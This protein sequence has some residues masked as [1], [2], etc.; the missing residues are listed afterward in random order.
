MGGADCT[1]SP[2]EVTDG[3]QAQAGDPPA[4]RRNGPGSAVLTEWNGLSIPKEG[5]FFIA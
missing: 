5:D 2:V 1:P 4:G 3:D